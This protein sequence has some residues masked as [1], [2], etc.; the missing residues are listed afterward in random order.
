MKEIH[1]IIVPIDFLEH[2]NQI[3]EY[4]GYIATKFAARLH[5]VHVVESVQSYVGYEYPSIGTVGEE[6]AARAEKMMQDFKDKNQN[7]MPVDEGK[8]IRGDIVDSIIQYTK[9]Q[10]GDLIILGTH[11][12]KGLS[13]MWL[14]SVAERVIKKA[15]C[16]TLTC[17]PYKQSS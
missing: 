8:V 9:E 15:P 13:K 14:G 4:A 1:K 17:N 6:M 7:T 2:T 3:V 16:P 11:G 10:K 12:R 5:F